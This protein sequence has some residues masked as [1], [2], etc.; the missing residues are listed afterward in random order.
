MADEKRETP[1]MPPTSQDEKA[2]AY[3]AQIGEYDRRRAYRGQN[4]SGL[5]RAL[6]IAHAEIGK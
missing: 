1:T 2:L 3:A 6:A 5:L 4:S